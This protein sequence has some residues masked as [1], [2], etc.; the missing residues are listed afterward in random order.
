MPHAQAS[1][2]SGDLGPWR[3]SAGSPSCRLTRPPLAMYAK[4]HYVDI[5]TIEGTK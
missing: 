3:V 5:R 1:P 2:Q 4:D